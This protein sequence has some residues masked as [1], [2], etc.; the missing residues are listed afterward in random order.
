MSYTLKSTLLKSIAPWALLAAGLCVSGHAELGHE[1]L[2]N[3]EKHLLDQNRSAGAFALNNIARYTAAAIVVAESTRS[4]VD[5]S[6]VPEDDTLEKLENFKDDA[7]EAIIKAEGIRYET[8][9]ILRDM[10]Q[11]KADGNLEIYLANL[12]SLVQEALS[13]LNEVMESYY[14]ARQTIEN[15]S[16]CDTSHQ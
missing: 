13:S 14:R 9:E 12:E 6:P 2:N 11:D 1:I 4:L 3:A 10:L 5:S 16:P 8:E 7:S 15:A